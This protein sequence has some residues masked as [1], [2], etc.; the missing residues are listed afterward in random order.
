MR[1]LVRLVS[2]S[3]YILILLTNRKV[4]G[5]LALDSELTLITKRITMIFT[6][7]W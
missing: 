5:M 2:G 1:C 3:Q 4:T 6:G 7:H